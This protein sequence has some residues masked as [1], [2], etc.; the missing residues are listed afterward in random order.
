MS[1]LNKIISITI[2]VLFI[3][4]CNFVT[5]PVRDVQEIAKTAESFASAIPLETLQA[6]PS[7]APTF[8]AL[9][10]A[11][12]DFG[13]YFNP[14]GTPVEIWRD[15][16]IMSQATA[17]QEFTDTNTYS[18]KAAVTAEEVQ[19]FY[20]EKLTG[21][22]WSQPFSVPGQSNGAIM[23]FQKDS[24]TLTITVVPSDSSVVVVLTLA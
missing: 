13:N 1:K 3:L 19:D 21:L 10:S 23:V 15:I 6:L 14:E 7:A 12:P 18:F 20:N 11:L 2:L 24:T 4:A 5:Q 16:P 9:A 22:G 8:Q 17:G